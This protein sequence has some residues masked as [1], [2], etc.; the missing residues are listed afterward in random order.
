VNIQASLDDL[1]TLRTSKSASEILASLDRMSLKG[2]L[3]GYEPLGSSS[4]KVA[5]FGN[6]F[7][8]DLIATIEPS[9]AGSTITFTTK[10]HAKAPIVLIV[11][12]VLSIW[13]GV[14]LTDSL[15]PGAWGWWP[16]WT[17]YMPLVILPL[18]YFLPKMW[19]KSRAESESHL[20]E[21]I[22]RIA[23]HTDCK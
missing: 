15:I 1:P 17:W 5:L 13:P 11:S 18:P 8:G 7:D 9:S 19:K 6:P 12:I 22:E 2:K 21:Q 4:F 14:M 10:L 23:A 16:T 20:L 3:P